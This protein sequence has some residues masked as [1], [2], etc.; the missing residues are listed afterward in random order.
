VG[1]AGYG[2]EVTEQVPL[3]LSPRASVAPANGL[4]PS[5]VVPSGIEPVGKRD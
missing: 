1:L 4:Q 2:L 3:G 5:A